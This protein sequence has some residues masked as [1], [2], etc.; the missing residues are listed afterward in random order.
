MLVRR[1]AGEATAAQVR[2]AGA[3]VWMGGAVR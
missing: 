1:W 3:G 2:E